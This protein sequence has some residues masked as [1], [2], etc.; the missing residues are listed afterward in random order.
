MLEHGRGFP[1]KQCPVVNVRQTFIKRLFDTH[2]HR[3]QG[4]LALLP[5]E[6]QEV[7]L[8]FV[9]CRGALAYQYG[10]AS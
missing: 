3:R 1:G 2:L 4:R 10:E 9:P 7:A 8:Q 5:I 6:Y